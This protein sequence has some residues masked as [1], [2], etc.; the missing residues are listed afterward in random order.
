GRSGKGHCAHPDPRGDADLGGPQNRRGPRRPGP[1]AQE[2]GPEQG[3]IGGRPVMLRH[4]A[5]TAT[6]VLVA[7]ATANAGPQDVPAPTA[8]LTQRLGEQIP[9]DLVFRDEQGRAVALREYFGTR[10][11]ILVLAY[12]RCPRLCSLVL[13]GLV[14]GLRGVDYQIGEQFEVV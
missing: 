14:E 3:E 12:Y 13:N 2:Q 5:L 4:A 1:H 7:A 9:L 11:V 6:L 8:V 10:P